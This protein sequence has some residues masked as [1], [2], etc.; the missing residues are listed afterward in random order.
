MREINVGK[1]RLQKLKG[2]SYLETCC[3][4]KTSYVKGKL[5]KKMK[6]VCILSPF[7]GHSVFCTRRNANSKGGGT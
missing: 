7:Q 5:C 2:S 4:D 3:K 1:E 6:C